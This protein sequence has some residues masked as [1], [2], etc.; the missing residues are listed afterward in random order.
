MLNVVDDGCEVSLGDA[1]NT[2][3][4]VL[5]DE[6]VVVPNNADHLRECEWLVKQRGSLVPYPTSLFLER[7]NSRTRLP[8]AA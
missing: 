6:T 4:H 3:T 2:V 8:V 5:G 1:D 7:G